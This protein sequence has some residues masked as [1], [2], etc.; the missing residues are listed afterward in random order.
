LNGGLLVFAALDGEPLRRTNFRRRVWLPAVNATV[1]E[2]MRFHDLRHT[3]ASWLIAQGEHA[4]VIQARFGHASIRTTLDIYGHLF[5][6]LD[7]AAADRL[8]QTRAAGHGSTAAVIPL[9]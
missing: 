4:K 8:D 5:D 1:G 9:R 6:G 3:Q 7:Q 2:P